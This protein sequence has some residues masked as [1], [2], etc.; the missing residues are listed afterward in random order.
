M[1]KLP[2]YKIENFKQEKDAT[3]YANDLNTHI[4]EHDFTTEAHK[5]DFYL[6]V[7]VTK[8]S[9]K[10]EIDFNSYDVKPGSVFV[11]NPGQ[12]HKWLLSS[13]I[14]GFVFFHSSEFY[15]QGF[16]IER[17]QNYPFYNSL[18]NLPLILFKQKE[19]FNKVLLF[20]E[21]ILTEY[22]QNKP[23]KLE[24]IH[25]L[26]TLVYIE[27]TRVYKPT[28]M[29]KNAHY[30]N[31]VSKLIDLINKHY[32]KH[33]FPHEYARLMNLSE[34]HVNR[35]CKDCL[36]KTT[37]DL[38]YERITLEAKRQLIHTSKSINE[39]GFELGFDDN[40]YFSRFFKKQTRLTPREF[41]EKFK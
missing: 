18:F 12:T 2:V 15:D 27:L 7:I 5:H 28:L 38:I 34:K 9:G 1:D 24:R 23:L 10:H 35:V 6:V 37:S 14:Q 30:L 19:N 4:R 41:A 25:A 20:F 29:P 11:L 40:S 8:G 26:V 16:T 21:E 3:F 33:K 39:I 31:Q 13:D 36:N 17:I 32:K 22:N